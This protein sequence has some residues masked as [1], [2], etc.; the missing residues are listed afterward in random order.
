MLPLNPLHSRMISLRLS[1]AEP[2]VLAAHG[3]ILDLRKRGLVPL[4]GKLQGPGVVH[5][6]EVHLKLAV[7]ALRILSI[8]PVMS[9]YPFAPRRGTG[10]EACPNILPGVQG[11]VGASLSDG[12]DATVVETIGGP[13][14]CFHIFT[15]MRLLGPSLATGWRRARRLASGLEAT[16]AIPGSP[17]FSRSIIVDGARGDGLSLVLRGLLFDLDYMP[18]AASLSL[19]EEMASS[20]EAAT[21]VEVEL[22]GMVIRQGSGRVRRTGHDIDAPGAWED[23]AIVERLAGLTM[24]KGYTAAVQGIF[25]ET[26]AP[27]PLQHLLFQLAPAMIQCMPSLFEEVEWRPRQAQGSRGAVDSCHMWRAGGPLMSL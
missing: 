15:L 12:Y 10:G 6:M 9:A 25:R 11:L 22:P 19:Q 5:D 2:G 26:E 18:G 1:W 24:Y 20:F 3:R 8:E 27:E 7:D 13:R 16:T 23:A 14:G 4:V 17:I 21:D